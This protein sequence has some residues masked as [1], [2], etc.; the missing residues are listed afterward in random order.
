MA[1]SKVNLKD[2]KI[3][4]ATWACEVKD[5][6]QHLD[7][8]PLFKKKFKSLSV[9]S[10]RESYLK[11]GKDRMNR[12]FLNRLKKE[13]PD[14]LLMSLSYDEFSPE[15]L[16]KIKQISPNTTTIHFF[17][18]DEWRYDDWSRHYAPFFDF[19][20]ISEKDISEYKKD[21]IG[22]NVYFLHGV[23]ES[24][25]KPTNSE[26]KYDVSFLGGAISDRPEYISFLARKKLNL[27]VSGRGWEEYPQLNK[28]SLPH[29]SQ[30]EYLEAINQS[31]INLSFSKGLI[32]GSKGGQLKGRVFE[33]MACN[34]FL[35]IEDFPNSNLFFRDINRIIFKTKEELLKKVNYFLKNSNE[36]EKVAEDFYNQ[37]LKNY[38]W[39]AQFQNFFNFISGKI[40]PYKKPI[41][42]ISEDIIYLSWD[43][44]K[45]KDL[46]DSLKNFDFVAFKNKGVSNL[47]WKNFFQIQS[48][49][50][51]G[52]DVSLCDFYA[53]KPFLGE[54]L[55]FN[56]KKAYNSI[57]LEEFE[58][59][60]DLSQIVVRKK[61]LIKNKNELISK[62]STLFSEKNLVFVSIPLVERQCF[63]EISNL[64]N[65]EISFQLRF[66]HEIY[67]LFKRKNPFLIIYLGYLI[68]G[69]Y[70]GKKMVLRKVLKTIKFLNK[71]G[72]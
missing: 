34:S 32:K 36:R 24:R 41:N 47:P 35:L 30:E 31:K 50:K 38:T 43:D 17:G 25:F 21:G 55:A 12:E 3:M 46:E 67:S 19:I 1:K 2:K 59:I 27:M 52:K 48:L 69:K 56:S 9:Y 60:I 14:F 63:S 61:W 65:M 39:E 16:L 26:K 13:K 62:R 71:K 72:K 29:L 45:R 54:Y 66:L 15:T 70:S 53:T 37:V 5:H 7:W 42:K 44:L 6:Y 22:S 10:P 68:F 11:F 28:V 58:R 57:P 33:V 20:I 8:I 64:N 4:L 51:S 23:N 49:N 40:S 18:D